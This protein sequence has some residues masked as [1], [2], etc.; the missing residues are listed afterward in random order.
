MDH[1]FVI[2]NRIRLF[3]EQ[4]KHD[5]LL[6]SCKK[7]SLLYREFLVKDAEIHLFTISFSYFHFHYLLN[8]SLFY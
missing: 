7:K 4:S 1:S 5:I 2:K 6:I 8:I 3:D